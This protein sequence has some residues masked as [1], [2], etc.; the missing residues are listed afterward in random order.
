MAKTA[1]ENMDPTW[2]DH[3]VASINNTTI[4]DNIGQHVIDAPAMLQEAFDNTLK[5]ETGL[6]HSSRMTVSAYANFHTC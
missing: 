2:I 3:F 5:L 6:R 4:G 1:Y